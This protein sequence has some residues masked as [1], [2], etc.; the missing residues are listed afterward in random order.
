MHSQAIL[1]KFI[2]CK[3]LSSSPSSSSIERPSASSPTSSLETPHHSHWASSSHMSRLVT[4]VTDSSKWRRSSCSILH[5]LGALHL[6]RHWEILSRHIHAHH[7]RGNK[8]WWP[9]HPHMLLGHS[10]HWIMRSGG[11][12]NNFLCCFVVTFRQILLTPK[13]SFQ[14]SSSPAMGSVCNIINDSLDEVSMASPKFHLDRANA[15]FHCQQVGLMGILF[16][17]EQALK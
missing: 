6:L 12:P 17:F 1:R 13:V 16:H 5:L 2:A 9:C 14:F 3:F 8:L 15:P 4:L 10:H 7:G 11:L